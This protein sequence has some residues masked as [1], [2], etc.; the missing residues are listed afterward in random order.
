MN[1][2]LQARQKNK[3]LTFDSGMELIWFLEDAYEQRDIDKFL[4]LVSIDFKKDFFKLKFNLER[5]FTANKKLDLYIL[6]QSKNSDLSGDI[7]SY[8]ICWSKRLIKLG[9]DY[10][11]RGFGK[12][13]LV[14]KRCRVYLKNNLMLFDIL[15][16][17][18]FNHF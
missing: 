6:L 11:Q 5:E 10:C 18:P 12:A 4:T 2:V 16:D 14:L 3:D 1:L 15:G 9:E 7:Y 8:E 17:S 13:T